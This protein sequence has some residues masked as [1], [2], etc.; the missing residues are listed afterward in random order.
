MSRKVIILTGP[1]GVGKTTIAEILVERNGFV[2]IDGDRLDT[3]FFPN[4]QQWLSE[5][6]GKLR[7]AHEKILAETKRIR[8]ISGKNVVVDYVIFGNH[9]NFIEMFRKEF[10]TDLEIR[11]LFPEKAEAIRRD[12]ERECWTAG[13]DRIAADYEEFLKIRNDIGQDNFIDT[14]GLTPDETVNRYFIV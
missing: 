3:E 9:L 7:L 2:R 11:V 1:G 13:P 4:G 8:D 14:T 12:A 10:E 6:S 5:N